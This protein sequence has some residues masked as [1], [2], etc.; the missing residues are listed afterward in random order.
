M[1]RRQLMRNVFAWPA[2]FVFGA[3]MLVA[4]GATN[5]SAWYFPGPSGRMIRQPDALGNRVLDFSGVGYKGG[6]VAIPSVATKTNVSP[7]AG[8]NAARLQAA[9]NYVSALPLDAN[10]FR[11]AVQLAPG[12]YPVSNTLVIAASGVVLR[13]AGEGGNTNN[14]TVL[15]A[16]YVGTA[17]PSLILFSNS[18]VYTTLTTHNITN[19][20]VPVGAR[21]FNV[22]STSGFSAG[23]TVF[24][25]RPSTSLWITNI[26][27]N[28]VSPAWTAGSF[29]IY[30]DRTITRVEGNSITLDAPLTCALEQQYGGG[31]IFSY[32]WPGRMTNVGVEN[33]RGISYFN[34]TVLTNTSAT[35]NYLADENHTWELVSFEGAIANGW[36][37][38]ITASNFAYAC[39][40][41]AGTS[42]S[43][44]G[45]RNITVRDCTSLDPV[46]EITGGR[47]YAF[48]LNDCQFCL[49][50][51][52]YTRNDRH[53]FVMQS[54]TVGPNVFV[55]GL[56]DIAWNDCGPH[57]RWSTGATWDNV[58]VHGDV[59]S[60]GVL[61]IRNRGNLGTSHGW[62]GANEVVWNSQADGFVVESPPSARNWL[63]GS[64][65]PLVANTAAIPYPAPAGTYDSL[66]TNVFPNSLYYA[67]LQDRLAAPNLETRE[68]WIGD[69]DNFSTSSP[70]G[71]VVNV[72]S[73]WR[74]SVQSAAGSAAVNG[75]D[76][77]A[78]NQWIP[79]TINFSL[80]A[81]DQIVGAT[82]ALA[83][84]SVSGNSSNAALFLDTT[85]S[86][87][88]F[89]N[90]GWSPIGAGT[91]TTV[92]VLD[93]GNQ[94]NLLADGKL[95][96]AVAGDVGIDWA[97]LE[98]LVTPAL[99]YVTNSIL[100]VADAYVRGGASSNLN[101]GADTTLPIKLDSSADN[102][103]RGFFRWNLAGLSN[104]FVQARIRLTPVSVGT[105]GIENGITLV[106]NS[107]WNEN[108]ITWSNQ[109]VGAK[110]FATWIPAANVPVE[111]V[112]TPQV[113]AA[114]ASD[115]QLSLEMFSLSNV[116]GPGTVSYASRE[117]GNA[118]QQP[119]LLLVSIAPPQFTNVVSNA[120]GG[121]TMSGT[122]PN[123]AGYRIL[124]ATN[125]AQPLGNWT[126]AT[127]GTFN[128]G[129]FNF[130]DLSATNFSQR[131]YRAVTP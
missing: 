6:G 103:R 29:D 93:L 12:F 109:P 77:V 78:T 14:N 97:M 122:G 8:D 102:Q 34:P 87:N 49:N 40:S 85:A 107:A 20:Y 17:Q 72:D 100:P 18:S 125:L 50:Q 39:V 82:L 58:T 81:T 114:L 23:T 61:A 80:A 126:P 30:P 131:F 53:Q 4:S 67:Q 70:T 74:T 11:G 43:K 45:V 48:V 68:Y 108:T 120:G 64:I 75:F 26:G 51:N 99:A 41:L 36:A 110:R 32:S 63:I 42:A 31:T 73:A 19:V 59:A 27:M 38:N 104:D 16:T 98:L 83:L 10:G 94:I 1:T 57:F 129:V 106:T 95:N 88:R 124:A 128:G 101:F 86:S 71:E 115:G 3:S 7:V 69:M 84:R 56:S 90:L 44:P 21:S 2:L 13:G 111:F 76:F 22:D 33:L 65:G 47:R 24:V 25:R 92:R 116:G 35:T 105:N 118:A 5:L 96:L 112:V 79:F 62:A 37:R 15:Y 117:N 46:S 54:L 113:Q 91:N 66:G 28:L 55:D 123:G 89:T 119:Q 9:I 60:D 127:T 130:T 121:F 52:C